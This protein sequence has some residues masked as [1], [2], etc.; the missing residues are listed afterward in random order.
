METSDNKIQRKEFETFI[1]AIG[2][3]IEQAQIKLI[4]AANVQMLL[5]Y[6]KVGYFI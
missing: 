2:L 6:W 1:H 4:A 3:E 5:H